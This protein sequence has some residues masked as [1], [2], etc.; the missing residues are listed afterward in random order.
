VYQLAPAEVETLRQCCRLVDLI[1]RAD[2]ELIDS[3]LVVAGSVGQL[4]VH[5]LIAAADEMRRTLGVLLNA[6]ALPFPAEEFGKRRSPA[7]TAAAQ[8]RWRQRRSS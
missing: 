4:R 3:D 8:E 2:V 6:L 1:D 7:A 5:P